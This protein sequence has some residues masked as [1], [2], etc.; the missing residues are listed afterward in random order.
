VSALA[1][2]AVATRGRR[3]LGLALLALLAG[4]A[5]FRLAYL[6]RKVYWNDEVITSLWF[7]GYTVNEVRERL[8]DREVGVADVLTSQQ[9]NPERGMG[10]FVAALALDD[11][12]HPP[13][14]YGL[15]RL[16]AGWF[17]DSVAAVRLLS[18]LLSLL[19][20]PCL[21]WLARELFEE[22]LTAW[23]AVALLAVSPFHVLYAQE[24]REYSLL[25]V[26]LLVSSAVLLRALRL[27]APR[28]WALYAVTVALGL[29]T[30]FLFAI[31]ALAHGAYVAGTG[32]R[33]VGGGGFRWPAAVK[34]YLAASLVG[35]AAFVP[36]V[37]VLVVNMTRVR[38]SLAWVTEDKS[39]FGL[40]DGWCLGVSSVFLDPVADR[41]SLAAFVPRLPAVALAVGSLAL[42]CYRTR[43][44]TWLLVLALVGAT[45]L[46]TLVPDLVLGGRR[47]SVPRYALAGHV[48]VLLAAAHLLAT[49]ITSP[50]PW[51]RRAWQVVLVGLVAGGLVSD[52]RSAQAVRWWNKGQ[53]N[54][55][56]LA[57]DVI[58]RAPRPLVFSDFGYEHFGNV[59][60]LSHRLEPRVRLWLMPDSKVPAVPDGFSDVFLFKPSGPLR[61]EFEARGYRVELTSAPGLCRLRRPAEAS[62]EAGSLENAAN[63]KDV[64]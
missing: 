25:T 45:W 30:S 24:A 28:W 29:Y 42:L 2:T 48:A 40:L 60:S 51:P 27:Q 22:R 54:N 8:G 38:E 19:A 23:V 62:G 18:A 52:A 33:A 53:Q 1:D 47:S 7:S 5:F 26:V 46:A 39:P 57:A 13:F 17:G 64:R 56:P 16:W 15:V 11:A 44:K 32:L 31:V 34:G 9:V 6:D 35:A 20:F 21:Y 10:S 12:H 37:V 50:R 41:E 58:N 14:Y 55:T 3:A 4:G 36:W 63:G 43:P 59:I 49:G 61:R